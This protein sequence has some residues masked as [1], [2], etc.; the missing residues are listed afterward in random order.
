MAVSASWRDRKENI[1]I[2]NPIIRHFS[3]AFIKLNTI[4]CSHFIR[5]E[6]KGLLAAFM[7]ILQV[8]IHYHCGL[9][10]LV[11]GEVT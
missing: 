2:I 11:L 7:L 8:Q 1:Y 6:G 5:T 9:G 3:V 10:S 4:N